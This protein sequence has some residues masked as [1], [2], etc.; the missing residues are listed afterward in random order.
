MLFPLH[1]IAEVQV[2]SNMGLGKVPLRPSSTTDL[3]FDQR[4]AMPMEV[5]FYVRNTGNEAIAKPVYAVL[6]DPPDICH[7]VVYPQFGRPDLNG[8]GGSSGTASIT[9][10]LPFL[11]APKQKL[12]YTTPVD[13][14]IKRPIVTLSTDTDSYRQV[15]VKLDIPKDLKVFTLQFE[16]SGQNLSLSVYKVRYVIVR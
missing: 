6:A 14:Q 7:G 12:S 13:A 9:P 15:I 8:C 3:A 4:D 1:P 5:L 16:V 10:D 2:D 11:G